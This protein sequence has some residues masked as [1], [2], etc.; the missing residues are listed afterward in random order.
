[1]IAARAALLLLLPLAAQARF[2]LDLAWLFG[3]SSG[4]T[5]VVKKSS[6]PPPALVRK[7]HFPFD[8]HGYWYSE[9]EH[10]KHT[11]R[12]H[13]TFSASRSTWVVETAPEHFVGEHDNTAHF[14]QPDSVDT[15]RGGK[16]SE[17]SF[18]RGNVLSEETLPSGMV[19][20]CARAQYEYSS[21]V[22][23]PDVR[24]F[25]YE[26]H[27]GE[28][29]FGNDRMVYAVSTV[30]YGCP[31]SSTDGDGVHIIP[32]ER[33]SVEL[34]PPKLLNNWVRESY[35]ARCVVER[36]LQPTYSR[37]RKQCKADGP[38]EEGHSDVVANW[39]TC[40]DSEVSHHW[41]AQGHKHD[42]VAEGHEA[43]S[44]ETAHCHH[45]VCFVDLASAAGA[46]SAH[47]FDF[48]KRGPHCVVFGANEFAQA[49]AAGAAE[50]GLPLGDGRALG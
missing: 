49:D 8:L 9:V 50:H 39:G 4:R 43:A 5:E 10:E 26:T 37:W 23:K 15:Y 30:D 18:F 19:C 2:F 16:R 1:M 25:G 46:D 20:V 48:L 33:R 11:V 38:V 45:T 41:A 7:Q 22:D 6:L 3:S 27:R 32:F 47:K 12:I 42:A 34:V 21:V 35:D 24:C 13:M 29:S 31:R 14:D 44:E 17:W 36:S 28:D 40:G